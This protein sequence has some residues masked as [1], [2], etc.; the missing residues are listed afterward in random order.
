MYSGALVIRR[1]LQA[2]ASKLAS[3]QP[4]GKVAPKDGFP[5]A[6]AVPQLPAAVQ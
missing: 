1:V 6:S 4:V 2:E 3:V 5:A